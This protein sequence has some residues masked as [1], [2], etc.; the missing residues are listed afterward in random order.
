M[1]VSKTVKTRVLDYMN[2]RKTPATVSEV[3]KAVV[4]ADTRNA[5]VARHLTRMVGAGLVVNVS[6]PGVVGKYRLA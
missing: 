1:K 3:S 4:G 2:K 6:Q 5:T